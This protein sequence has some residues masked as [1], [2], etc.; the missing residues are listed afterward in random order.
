[1]RPLILKVY[2]SLVEGSQLLMPSVCLFDIVFVFVFVFVFVKYK[3]K[4][5]YKYNQKL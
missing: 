1:M 3:Y 2:L 4:Y 5:K